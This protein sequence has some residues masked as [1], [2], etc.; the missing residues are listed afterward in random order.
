MWCRSTCPDVAPE[1]V[2]WCVQI[3]YLERN[4][5]VCVRPGAA[6]AVVITDI[7]CEAELVG[8]A[9][10]L[11]F[12]T[13]SFLYHYLLACVTIVFLVCRNVPLLEVWTAWDCPTWTGSFKRPI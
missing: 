6:Q 1:N 5:E 8:L 7:S 13:V 9:N 10:Y 3:A 12:P 2:T 11:S 4:V